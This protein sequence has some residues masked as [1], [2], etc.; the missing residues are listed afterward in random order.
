MKIETKLLEGQ[1]L[2]WAVATA[3][4]LRLHKDA[5]L[6]GVNMR[7]W[8]ISGL[9]DDPNTWT[10]LR[11]FQPSSN[12]VIGGPIVSE[13]VRASERREGYH[14]ASIEDGRGNWFWSYGKDLLEAGMRV[15]V[16]SKLGAEVDVPGDLCV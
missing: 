5:L 12:W 13:R 9:S 6:G 2:D 8:W 10:S 7:G 1:A 3:L 4:G 16:M 14:Y 15:F 11:N